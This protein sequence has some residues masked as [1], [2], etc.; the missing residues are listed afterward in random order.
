MERPKPS[1]SDTG[2]AQGVTRT[3]AE[4]HLQI[5]RPVIYRI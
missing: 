1:K 3:T 2:T 4:L 5:A